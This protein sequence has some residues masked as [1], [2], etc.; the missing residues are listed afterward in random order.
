MVNN[1]G[2]VSKYHNIYV[3][4]TKEA[5]TADQYIEKTVHDI[6]KRYN[7]KVATSDAMEQM[8]ILGQGAQRMSAKD[9]WEDIQCVQHEIREEHL[10]NNKKS[11]PYLFDSLPENM[12]QFMDDVRMGRSEFKEVKNIKEGDNL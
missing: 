3:V 8:I 7:V 1:P 5:E 6:A 10:S 9:L 12:A 11:N 4:Y 2:E